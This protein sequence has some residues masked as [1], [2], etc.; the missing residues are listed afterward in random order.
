MDIRQLEYFVHVAELGSFTRAASL[1]SIA[2]PALSRQVRLLETELKQALLYRNGRGVSMTDAGKRLLEH[3]RGILQQVDRAR[4]EL[5]REAGTPVGRVIVAAPPSVE[6]FLTVPLVKDF[7]GRF[8]AANLAMI[9]GLSFYIQE[10]LV[11]G[12]IDIGIAYN[13]SP[14]PAL[15]I[16]PFLE[17]ELFLICPGKPAGTQAARHRQADG[18]ALS[19]HDL[20]RHP[21]I[22][23]SRPNAIRMRVET[24]LA[25]QGLKPEVALEI[26]GVPAILDLVLEGYG[27][28][29]LP[30][31][32]IR[33]QPPGRFMARPFNKRLTTHLA[34]VVPAQRPGTPLMR[35]TLELIREIGP[36]ILAP[37]L[38]RSGRK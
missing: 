31:N 4:D 2:Q 28:A 20:P 24:Q 10:W 17:E 16:I 6:K 12:R 22:I 9:G 29:V 19:L 34:L 7:R 38:P 25:S 27:Y 15:E 18:R 35:M 33:G 26:D 11:T 23:P 8:P 32:A 37:T 30:M 14:S 5:A 21:L 36:G 1:L 3:A 13:P